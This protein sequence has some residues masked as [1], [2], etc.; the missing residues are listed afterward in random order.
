MPKRYETLGF[1]ELSPSRTANELLQH[2]QPGDK[3]AITTR[4]RGYYAD[5]YVK[6]LQGRGIQAR[7]ITGQEGVED[8]CFLA[9]AQREVIGNVV[10]SYARWAAILG[11]ASTARL[12]I[13]DTSGLRQHTKNNGLL[14]TLGFNWTNP[15]LQSRVKFE[16]Y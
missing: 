2:L 4:F 7:L 10:S 3:V 14:R 15:T 9:K 1:T 12:Y 13:L 8:F 6:A 5:Q 16:V 11:N